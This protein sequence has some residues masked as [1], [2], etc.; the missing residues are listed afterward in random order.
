MKKDPLEVE[1]FC[2]VPEEQQPCN[3][4]E[5]LKESSF[6]AWP[7]LSSW[8]YFQKLFWFSFWGFFLVAPLVGSVFPPKVKPLH[9]VIAGFIGLAIFV[10]LGILRLYLGWIY[11]QQRLKAEKVFYEESGWYDG[12]VWQKPKVVLDRDLLIVNYQIEPII[13]RLKNTAA[14]LITIIIGSSTLWIVLDQF[15]SN[16]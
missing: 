9:F 8:Q 13:K 3:E 1:F 5:E 12:Q 10:G 15:S 14:I 16:Q 4:Y 6:F 11:V 2:P 7:R